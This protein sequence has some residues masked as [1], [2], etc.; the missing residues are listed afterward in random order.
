MKSVINKSKKVLIPGISIKELKPLFNLISPKD[1]V[2]SM[3]MTILVG[4]ISH[5]LQ[6]ILPSK[7]IQQVDS[8]KFYSKV[9]FTGSSIVSLT[10]LQAIAKTLGPELET[11]TLLSPQ[12]RLNFLRSLQTRIIME[13]GPSKVFSKNQFLFDPINLMKHRRGLALQFR[14]II[15]ANSVFSP[16]SISIGF[17][18]SKVGLG[19]ILQ[20]SKIIWNNLG[21]SIEEFDFVLRKE[22][23]I[24]LK[25]FLLKDLFS[26]PNSDIQSLRI[27]V[28]SE[29]LK[30]LPFMSR[31]LIFSDDIVILRSEDNLTLL[32]RELNFVERRFPNIPSN[33]FIL[34]NQSKDLILRTALDQRRKQNLKLQNIFKQANND[35]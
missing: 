3:V 19:D 23:L 16:H 15:F 18:V 11:L 1:L 6:G 4:Q 35:L 14:S 2:V 34:D 33:I 12:E 21:G 32:E 5:D 26:E 27:L 10:T 29:F 13:R 24:N 30:V 25:N 22:S 7:E 28:Y 8:V 9:I 31:E 20:S 17:P